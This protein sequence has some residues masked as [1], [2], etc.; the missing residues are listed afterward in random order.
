MIA[1]TFFGSEEAEVYIMIIH[2]Y[3]YLVPKVSWK[4]HLQ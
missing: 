3:S 1:Y 4:D 2:M